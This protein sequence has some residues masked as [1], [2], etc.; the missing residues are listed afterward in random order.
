MHPENKMMRR[1]KTEAEV[2]CFI[3]TSFFPIFCLLLN[4]Q[5]NYYDTL[6]YQ[7]VKPLSGANMLML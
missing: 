7:F 6:F 2:M 3:S 4:D 1:E 5:S